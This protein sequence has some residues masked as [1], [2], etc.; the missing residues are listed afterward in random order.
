M[1]THNI[2]SITLVGLV[3]LTSSL[4]ASFVDEKEMLLDKNIKNNKVIGFINEGQ[5]IEALDYVKAQSGSRYEIIRII[6]D[7]ILESNNPDF[8]GQMKT[9]TTNKEE[10]KFKWQF[11]SMLEQTKTIPA[12]VFGKAG[13]SY[14]KLKGYAIIKHK[15]IGGDD[16]GIMRK[17]NNLQRYKFPS[18]KKELQLQKEERAS[19]CY[20]W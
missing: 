19:G 4:K 18:N 12:T 5:Y 7:P 16:G 14:S 9:I 3:L 13:D 2:F 20:C 10:I 11:E 8:K 6:S 17:T 15:E 1:K